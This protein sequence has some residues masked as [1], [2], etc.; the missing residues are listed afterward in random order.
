M[1]ETITHDCSPAGRQPP[2]MNLDDKIDNIDYVDDQASNKVVHVK[3][4]ARRA[5]D[6]FVMRWSAEVSCW[7]CKGI[8]KVLH[9]WELDYL[10]KQRCA[11]D[12]IKVFHQYTDTLTHTWVYWPE[13]NLS[14][15]RFI[16]EI[17]IK[18]HGLILTSWTQIITRI[19]IK[20]FVSDEDDEWEISK[21]KDMNTYNEI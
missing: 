16:R 20:S 6:D 12:V 13:R 8:Q 15:I 3:L 2:R 7:R 4:E 21:I 17:L 9:L 5:C 10:N 18:I 19:I 11:V 14:F 1:R